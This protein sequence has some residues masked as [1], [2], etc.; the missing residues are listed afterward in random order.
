[1][2][3]SAIIGKLEN[4]DLSGNEN[5]N[6]ILEIESLR[7]DLIKLARLNDKYYADKRMYYEEARKLEK[8]IEEIIVTYTKI[9]EGKCKDQTELDQTV[10]ELR[11]KRDEVM[12]RKLH[13]LIM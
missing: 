13:S 7:A 6:Y 8:E 10:M 4:V 11:E 5:F 9:A 1:M 3:T 2:K 12:E